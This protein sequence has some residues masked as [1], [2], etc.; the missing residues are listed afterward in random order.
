METPMLIAVGFL[1]G[2]IFIVLLIGII[3]DLKDEI[4]DLKNRKP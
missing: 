4:A 2:A 1:V 3:L